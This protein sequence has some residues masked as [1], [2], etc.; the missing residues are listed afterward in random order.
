VPPPPSLGRWARRAR[1]LV[2]HLGG[3]AA[4]TASA[5]MVAVP[6]GLL[7]AGVALLVLE[8]LTSEP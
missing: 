3:L 4:V 1:S 6:L 2:L 8:Y 5:W 7:V